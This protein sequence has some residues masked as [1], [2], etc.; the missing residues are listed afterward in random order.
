LPTQLARSTLLLSA[1]LTR[2]TEKGTT[3][4]AV[5]RQSWRSQ[6]PVS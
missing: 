6:R 4:V 5:K 2:N 1:V 3:R